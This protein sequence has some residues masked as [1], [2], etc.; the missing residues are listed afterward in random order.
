MIVVV[1]SGPLMALGKLELLEILSRLY[2]QVRLPTAVHT[3]VVLQVLERGYSDAF[4]VQMA[5]QG[6]QLIVMEVNDN[7]LPSDIAVLPL[8]IG[9]KQALYLALRDKADLV[10][11]DDLKAREEAQARGLPIK[12]TLGIIAHAYRAGLLS[13]DEVQKLLCRR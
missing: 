7:E 8:D 10:L 6:R 11:F 5:I 9:E 12:G 2:G 3:E 1:N 13:I 4:L